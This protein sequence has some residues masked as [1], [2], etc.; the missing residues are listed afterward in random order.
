MN[1][2]EFLPIRSSQKRKM[3][4]WLGHEIVHI[5]PPR[6]PPDMNNSNEEPV[7]VSFFEIQENIFLV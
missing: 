6:I 1:Y 7:Y 3:T 4:K 2:F 5:G